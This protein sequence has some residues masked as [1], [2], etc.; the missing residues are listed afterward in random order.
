MAPYLLHSHNVIHAQVW[1]PYNP[2]ARSLK[3]FKYEQKDV[4]SYARSIL[5]TVNY[6]NNVLLTALDS[7][8]RER[9]GKKHKIKRSKCR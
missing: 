2:G 1:L 9:I 7:I 8:Y 6:F 4:F 3:Q 5:E